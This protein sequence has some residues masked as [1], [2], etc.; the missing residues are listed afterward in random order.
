MTTILLGIDGKGDFS[1]VGYGRDMTNSFV[2]Y[3]IRHSKVKLKR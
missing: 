1:N 2:A 3:I